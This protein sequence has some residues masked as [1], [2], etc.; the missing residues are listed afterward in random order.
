MRPHTIILSLILLPHLLFARQ[1]NEHRENRFVQHQNWYDETLYDSWRQT[2]SIDEVLFEIK[3]DHQKL[4]IFKNSEYGNVLALDGIIQTTERDE[5]AYHEMMVH[6]P[7]LSHGNAQKV[8]IIGGGDGGILREVLRHPGVKEAVM[9]EIDQS[10]IDMCREFFPGHSAGAFDDPRARIVIADG[11]D[12]VSQ[13]DEKFDV[14]ISDSTDPIGAAEKLFT[15]SFYEYCSRILTEKGI[16]VCQNGV[17][18][19]QPKE[20]STTYKN[21]TPHFADVGF[22]TTVVPTY[23]GGIM[24]LGWATNSPEYRRISVELLQNRLL[25]VA[26]KMRYYT[27]E[28]HKASFAL[29]RF[30]M[31]SI[32]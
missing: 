32:Q 2:F 20:L 26:G 7:I 9:V 25:T 28:V 4:I 10:V 5:F 29:P 6:V 15:T 23:A 16:F 1:Q 17:P 24:T 30:I 27:P 8:L 12:F 11:Y 21:L 3:T 14:I 31:D 19:M 22:Y 13:T 18:F